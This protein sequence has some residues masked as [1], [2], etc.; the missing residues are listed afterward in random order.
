MI[1]VEQGQPT[2]VLRDVSVLLAEAQDAFRAFGGFGPAEHLPEWTVEQMHRYVHE[3]RTVRAWRLERWESGPDPAPER[4]RLIVA[5]EALAHTMTTL[6]NL[7]HESG[8][9]LP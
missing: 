1:Y 9:P 7:A 5:L 4:A 8:M 3:M 2:V 6:V